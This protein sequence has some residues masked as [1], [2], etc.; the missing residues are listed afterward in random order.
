MY[1]FKIES[2]GLLTRVTDDDEY[3]VPPF[4]VLA[5]LPHGVSIG[6]DVTLRS[7]LKFFHNYPDLAYVF[8]ELRYLMDFHDKPSVGDTTGVLH[9]NFNDSIS[10]KPYTVT[11]STMVPLDDGSGMSRMDFHYDTETPSV[12]NNWFYSFDLY[13]DETTYSISFTPIAEIIDLPVV[14]GQ[15]HF[16][17]TI[18]EEHR[19][20]YSEHTYIN[21]Y[22]LIV[23]ITDDIMFHGDEET[24]QDVLEDLKQRM[25]EIDKWMDNKDD[26]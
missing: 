18:D 8:T 22:D 19:S 16:H 25:D 7:I 21:M 14:M 24:K 3:V 5:T 6:E 12:V 1:M 13:S 4:E 10:W 17:V 20:E 26:D 15:M 9:I 11:G 23:A 2:T